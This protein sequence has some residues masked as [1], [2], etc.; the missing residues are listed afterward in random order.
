[1]IQSALLVIGT[2]TY[3]RVFKAPKVHRELKVL[4]EPKVH[5]AL[6]VRK[7]Q[8]ELRVL[9]EL[10][11]PKDLKVLKDLRVQKAPKEPKVLKVLMVTLTATRQPLQ[12]QLLWVLDR[13]TLSLKQDFL[14][15]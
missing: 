13:R 9:R 7:V 12:L 11:E 4:K 3:L 2:S 14:T 15:Q 8:K 6:K 10:R 5:R 1:V